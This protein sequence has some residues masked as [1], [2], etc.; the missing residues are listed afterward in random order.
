MKVNVYG[1]EVEIKDELADAYKKTI[2]KFDSE[3]VRMLLVTDGIKN[4]NLSAEEL[5]KLANTSISK[6]LSVIDDLNSPEVQAAAREFAAKKFA[7][8]KV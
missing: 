6:E 4:E 1:K 7:E 2:G 8:A 3:D 5:S